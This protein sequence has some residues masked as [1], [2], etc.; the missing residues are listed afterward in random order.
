M[1]QTLLKFLFTITFILVSLGVHAQFRE[2][3]QSIG[4]S[5]NDRVI[6]II[7]DE[8][9]NRYIM[10]EIGMPGSGVP[11]FSEYEPEEID[12]GSIKK[13]IINGFIAKYDKNNQCLWVRE[14]PK[15]LFNPYSTFT[16]DKAGFVY[17][18]G[19]IRAGNYFF[20]KLD[21]N[22]DL[23]WEKIYPSYFTKD[24]FF[25]QDITVDAEGNI[26]MVGEF[27]GSP[28]GNF[29]FNFTPSSTSSY[30]DYVAK[31]NP[32]GEA[33]WVKTSLGSNI[34]YSDIVID[35]KGNI[36]TAGGFKETVSLA[37]YTFENTNL[38]NSYGPVYDKLIVKRDPDGNVIWAR[39]YPLRT[40][41]YLSFVLDE[42]D[43]IYFTTPSS[44]GDLNITIDNVLIDRSKKQAL[45]KLD[46]QGTVQ[47]ATSFQGSYSTLPLMYANQRLYL[48]GDFS[49]EFNFQSK[50]VKS[51]GAY[52]NDIFLIKLNLD[53]EALEVKGYGG[54]ATETKA[55]LSYLPKQKEVV[56][57]GTF[58]EQMPN[59]GK[60]LVSKGSGDI[61]IAQ[62]IDSLQGI[63]P[64]AK[65]S[66]R[67]YEDK[68]VNCIADPL[69]RGLAN[70][71]LKIEPGQQYASTD[72]QGNFAFRVPYGSHT[73]TPVFGLN[74][75]TQL[76]TKCVESVQVVADSLHQEITG[77][78]LG[79]NIVECSQLTVD[80]AADRRR[81]CFRSNTTVTYTNDGNVDAQNV[82]IKVIYP[83][84][85]VPISSARPWTAKLDSALVFDIGTVKAGERTSFV[86]TD[87]TICGNEAIR[88]LSQCIKAV[89]TPKSTCEMPDRG[90]GKASVA[91]AGSFIN[92]EQ[93]AEFTIANRGVAAMSDST[94]YR[95]FANTALIKEGKVKL[96]QGDSTTLEVPAQLVTYR[97]EA[98]QVQNH[99]GKSRPTISLQPSTI[100]VASP[101]A[102]VLTPV[103]AF[104]QDDADAEV[105]ISCLTIIDSFDPNDK[106]VSPR[107]ITSRNYI[108]AEDDLEY[109]IRFQNT[110]TD[111]AYKVVV[112]DT[113][114]ANLDITSLRVRSASHPF[115]YSVSGKGNAVLTFTFEGINLPAAKVDEPGSHGF[116]KFSIAQNPDNPK[117]TVI[118]NTAYNYFDFNSPIATNEVV[119]IIGDTLIMSPTP[120]VVYDCSEEMPDIAQAGPDINLCE[121]STATLQANAPTKGI[122]KWVLVNGQA[123]IIDPYS[124]TSEVQD[125]GYGETILEW[126][127]TLCRNVSRAQVKISRFSIPPAPQIT[128]LP[129]Q[130]EGDN[131]LPITATGDNI[132][133]YQDAEKQ[134]KL[135]TG[136]NYV[137]VVSAST[138]L[139]ATQTVNGCESPVSSTV[140]GIHPK[141]VLITAI[142]DTLV[143]PQADSY[144]W[145]FN[146]EPIAAGTAQKLFVRNSGQYRVRT[147]TNGCESNSQNIKHTVNL[148]ASV[149]SIAPNPVRD[150]LFLELAS[151]ATGEVKIVVRDQL[152]KPV[153]SHTILKENTV[154]ELVL[155]LEKLAPSMYF[156]DVQLNNEV[157][158]AKIVKL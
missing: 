101:V 134:F 126:T 33:L 13:D 74:R 47:W 144:Q 9:D 17:V 20:Q 154:L 60:F 130:C 123:T 91:V 10:G 124:P 100:P 148:P 108:K 119:N 61:F 76:M 115:T 35:S 59:N 86:I 97:L 158:K 27:D 156:L 29:T 105:D 67:L 135:F 68:N 57:A 36:I 52:R 15:S 110:G 120:A 129:L 34:S 5:Y 49:G 103:D 66:G 8:D 93:T 54:I 16:I 6:K 118:R 73:I 150:E 39:S 64:T 31:F 145:F 30:T 69:E 122:G 71:L 85:V 153:L 53:G 147:I 28:I 113:L 84:Y 155:Q 98:D 24:K 48:A 136:N 56:L 116:I 140:V 82:R 131:L 149:L 62:I 22:G 50:V 81:R 141:E 95:L 42:D 1:K 83:K 25:T 138:T 132:T 77:L 18:A 14:C 41:S 94:S 3:I 106:Q 37:G 4:G 111:V 26:Y 102:D 45:L 38:P 88:G 112:K 139:Y 133:W 109:L 125:I 90:W 157:H 72:E 127:I 117:G 146:D 63:E 58:Y 107:G 55:A 114:S 19:N 78:N 92:Q 99:P 96:G 46:Q 142:N 65:I 75:N 32:E 79:Y 104:Y 80:I 128:Q 44:Y 21:P 23:V 70:T 12:F 40:Y 7:H 151:K 143:A 121:A 51:N 2:N 87:S 43:N 137:P 152:G 11:N 89:I